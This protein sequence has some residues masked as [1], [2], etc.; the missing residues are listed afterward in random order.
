MLNMEIGKEILLLST[1]ASMDKELASEIEV[2]NETHSVV[3]YNHAGLVSAAD[4]YRKARYVKSLNRDKNVVVDLVPLL[5]ITDAHF[6]YNAFVVNGLENYYEEVIEVEKEM[7]SQ[8][9]SPEAIKKAI[10]S[11]LSEERDQ[12]IPNVY[13]AIAEYLYDDTNSTVIETVRHIANE[14]ELEMMELKDIMDRDESVSFEISTFGHYMVEAISSLEKMINKFNES[15][16]SLDLYKP[17]YLNII[18]G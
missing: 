10:S 15:L 16:D 17:D 3:Y 1:V 4:I 14:L 13:V 2:L 9:V 5:S 11:F 8:Y 7:L 18:K 12:V 6:G